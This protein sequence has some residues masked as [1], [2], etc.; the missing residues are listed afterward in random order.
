MLSFFLIY[1]LLAPSASLPDQEAGAGKGILDWHCHDFVLSWHG[2]HWKPILSFPGHFRAFTE[3]SPWESYTASFWMRVRLLPPCLLAVSSCVKLFKGSPWSHME[4]EEWGCHSTLILS[5]RETLQ[6]PAH[7]LVA[8]GSTLLFLLGRWGAKIQKSD[9]QTPYKSYL[10]V[11]TLLWIARAISPKTGFKD[12]RHLQLHRAPPS[13]RP[14]LGL[15]LSCSHLGLL[16]TFWTS[17]PAFSLWTESSKLCSWPW[18][19]PIK[20]GLL[21]KQI[22]LLLASYY[23]CFW[24]RF[25]ACVEFSFLSMSKL[26]ENPHTS[27]WALWKDSQAGKNRAHRRQRKDILEKRFTVENKSNLRQHLLVL[28]IKFN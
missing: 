18:V 21:L 19:A 26:R 7:S 28:S 12:I 11:R 27:I 15:M 4:T 8:S 1:A 25:Q 3:T 23:T 2:R 13:E 9:L 20:L 16:N 10:V 24:W 14:V 17:S 5:S 6:F 22:S